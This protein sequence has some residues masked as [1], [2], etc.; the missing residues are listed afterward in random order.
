MK[1]CAFHQVLNAN[2][3]GWRTWSLGESI[4]EKGT[5]DRQ[6]FFTIFHATNYHLR[7]TAHFHLF[8]LV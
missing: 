1:L 6:P 7:Y 8:F 5:G 2:G 4:A 3:S